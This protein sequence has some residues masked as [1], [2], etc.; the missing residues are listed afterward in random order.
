MLTRKY[1][2]LCML[3]LLFPTVVYSQ[4]AGGG[5]SSFQFMDLP[6]SSRMAAL[7]GSNVSIRD[8][9]ISMAMSN[10]ALLGVMT[11][12]VLSLNFAYYLPGTAFG[13]VLYGHNF[14]RSS[15]E[16]HPEEPDK[17]NYFAVGLH[18]LDYGKMSYADEFGIRGGSF[19]ARDILIDVMYARQ[20]NTYLSIGVTLKP[21][22]SFYESYSA[23]ALGADV[24]LHFQLPDTAFQMGLSLQNIGWQLKG[25]YT[26][27]GGQVREILPLNLQLG[28]N[29]RFKHAPIRL[30]MTIHNIQRWNLGYEFTN[31]PKDINP[32]I[33][34]YDMLF[35]HTIFFLDIVPKSDRFYLSL[36]YNHRRRAELSLQDQR[37]LAGF[38]IGV[39]VRIYKFRLGFTTYQ[40]TKSNFT[41]QVSLS[42]DINSMLK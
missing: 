14:G 21:I 1:Y 9:E 37:S 19:S 28:F 10:P 29:Y 42:L 35:R 17:P 5:S 16:K 18:Y 24:G 4:Y 23:F 25:F 39:G 36:S 8:G 2:R 13:S 32:A 38:A 26:N 34:W 7:G 20:L 12:N 27:E 22:M 33:P 6:V 30:G 3:L 15:I 41:Y 40:A 31:V 11:D